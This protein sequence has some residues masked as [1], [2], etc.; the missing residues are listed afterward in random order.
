MRNA[1]PICN[2]DREWN[3][4]HFYSVCE[5]SHVAILDAK[6]KLSFALNLEAY[7]YHY[8]WY[9]IGHI[10]IFSLSLS[11]RVGIALFLWLEY[12]IYSLYLRMNSG[13]KAVRILFILK[14]DA[15]D[16]LQRIINTRHDNR[17][18]N[19]SYTVLIEGPHHHLSRAG[20]SF[21]SFS[22]FHLFFLIYLFFLLLG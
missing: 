1:N 20:F 10:Y 4:I 6:G 16:R 11:L 22:P 21:C 8:C 2:I 19:M 5:F 14:C 15:G 18:Y 7:Q 9:I 3:M 13:S 17:L 12:V